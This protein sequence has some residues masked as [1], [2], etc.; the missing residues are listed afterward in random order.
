MCLPVIVNGI[1]RRC[2]SSAPIASK[3]EGWL[4]VDS[5]FPIR[6]A[7]WDLRYYFGH[8]RAPTLLSA[9]NSR[10]DHVNA[11]DFSVLSVH[12]HHN[13]G[14][15]F[16]RFAY[17]ASD[18]THALA[19][20]SAQLK[21][22]AVEHGHI[23]SW[24]GFHHS[25]VWLVCGIP[26]IEDLD[27]FPSP[28]VCVF[29]DGTEIPPEDV[30]YRLFRP[31]GHIRE[32]ASP[33]PSQ[34]PRSATITFSR[35]RDATVA[36]N[37]LNGFDFSH[38]PSTRFRTTYRRHVQPHIMR[39]WLSSHPKITIP[40]LVFLLGTFTYSVF[41]PIRSWIVEARLQDSFNLHNSKF[42]AWT[43]ANTVGRLSRQ[44]TG[45][46]SLD[47]KPHVWRDREEATAALRSYLADHPNSIAFVHGPQG[48]GKS[49][50]VDLLL[51]QSGRTTLI[52]DCQLLQKAQSDTQVIA[53][54]ASQTG[55][56]PFFTF[57]SSLN[58]L[59]DLASVGI[60]GQKVGLSSSLADELQRILG[61]VTS[62][63]VHVSSSHRAKMKRDIQRSEME[64]TVQKQDALKRD[65]IL[66]GIWH[67]G[68]LD[69]VAGIGIISELG[70]G[71]ESFADHSDLPLLDVEES[72][73]G[74]NSSS[75]FS[76]NRRIEKM[77][78]VNGALPVVVI[79]NYAARVGPKCDEVLTE[80]G[81]WAATL[82]ENQVSHVIVISDNRDNSRLLGKE[83]RSKPLISVAIS[84]AD[85][86]SS[87]FY[88]QQKLQEAG[89]HV[90]FTP[91]EISFIERL[92]GRAKD[93][94]S[95]VHRLCNEQR[96]EDAVADIINRG[97][98]ELRKTAFGH[99]V[100]DAKNLPWTREQ[101]WTIAK[102]LANRIEIPYHK[103]LLDFPFNGDETALRNLEQAEV[104]SVTTKDGRPS[105]IQPGRPVLRWVFE[106]LVKDPI[107]QATQEISL[108]QLLIT[109]FEK[110][111][112]EC[113][114]ELS[115]LTP[116][117]TF[118]ERLWWWSIG[119]KHRHGA[120]VRVRYLSDK[121][122]AC[123]R[124]IE[125]LEI[126]NR[127][128]AKVLERSCQ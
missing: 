44:N 94:D 2:L 54:L 68:R 36:R 35:V 108:N 16:V 116:V 127:E 114:E 39:E 98:E 63:L 27:R 71:D 78:D 60:I 81:R 13:D 124:K 34:T 86:K 95:L 82:V 40:L 30:L 14:G 102:S 93:M 103:T 113:E 22:L 15:L 19:D 42:Y 67:D 55:Y 111:L 8:L 66:N 90:Q 104:V 18:T 3:H 122:A 47:H 69:C 100:D 12:P 77:L 121:I 76:R 45:P 50:I 57:L 72:L 92:G 59:L 11:H 62:A 125:S 65:K 38:R 23:P 37:V 64:L 99:D 17:S 6:F 21:R 96:V 41:D 73:E 83:L 79:R 119:L 128:I 75:R 61:V 7:R 117:I 9:V 25:R 4:F 126:I 28:V 46:S 20:I 29:F 107:F 32:I 115:A 74:D 88:V 1:V 24:S 70:V 106:K 123:C 84:D 105:V 118:E 33:T 80:L 91:T 26:W 101:A 89:I 97:V 85:P 53:S 5:L 87:V 120:N 48:A 51:S 43:R 31:Y 49:E 10:L 58:N 52:I 112:R 109:S 110:K 56:W